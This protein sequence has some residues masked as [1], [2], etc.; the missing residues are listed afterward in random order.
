MRIAKTERQVFPEVFCVE[1]IQCVP[2]AM[3]GHDYRAVLYHDYACI[4]V[5]FN[6]AQRDPKLNKGCFV[7]IVWAAAV[8]SDQGAIK[9]AG[10]SVRSRSVTDFNPFLNVPRTWKKIDRHLIHCARDLWDAAPLALRR[11][12]R[13]LLDANAE[14]W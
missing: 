2:G 1:D 5:S 12:L 4:T 10:L 13:A 9:V 14:R 7:T 3:G 11:M 8:R 6:A